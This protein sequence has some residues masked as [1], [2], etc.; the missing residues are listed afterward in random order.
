MLRRLFSA[1]LAMDKLVGFCLLNTTSA[2]KTSILI[3]A[4]VNDN[5]YE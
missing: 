4:A 3:K 1:S 5:S 2:S